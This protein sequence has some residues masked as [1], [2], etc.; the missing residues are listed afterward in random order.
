MPTIIRGTT[1]PSNRA[2]TAKVAP[3]DKAPTSPSQIR[4]GGMLKY[5]NAIMLPIHKEIKMDTGVSKELLASTQ[6]ANKE[7]IRS[8]QDK[9]SRP[10]VKLKKLAKVTI[11]MVEKMI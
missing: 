1:L 8:P 3:K 9:P 2:I 11:S 7:I 4:A 10:S 6:K 5:K